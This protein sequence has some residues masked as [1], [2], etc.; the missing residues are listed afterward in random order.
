MLDSHRSTRRNGFDTIVVGGGSAGCVLASRLSEDGG[1]NVLLLEAGGWDRSPYLRIPAG[2]L[3]IAKSY[4]WRYA[5]EPDDTRAGL[6]DHW[7]AGRVLGGGSS[8]NGMMW[9]R[10]HR[11]D[12]D[13]WAAAGCDG[14]SAADVQP[15][16]EKSETFENGPA[17]GR[18]LSGPVHV[19]F[20]RSPQPVTEVFIRAAQQAG[21][22]WNDDFNGAAQEG[23]SRGQGSLRRGWR[24]STVR[25]YLAPAGHRRNL[26]IRTGAVVHRVL[27]DGTRAAGVEYSTGG[28]DVQSVKCRGEVILSAGTFASPKLLMLSGIGPAGPLRAHGIEVLCDRPGVGQNL[29]EHPY[30]T[31]MYGVSLHTLNRDLN[32]VGIARHGL[33]FVFRGRGALATPFGHGIVFGHLDGG[34]QGP[35]DLQITFAPFGVGAGKGRLAETLR[36]LAEASDK[37]GDDAGE[38]PAHRHDVHDMGLLPESSVTVMACVLHPRGRGAVRLRSADPAASP[39][40]DHR[41]FAEPEDVRAM[42]AACRA[43]RAI[44][45]A[46]ALKEVVTGELLPGDAV[47]SSADWDRFVRRF[48]F[49]GEHGVGTCRMGRDEDAVVDP[50]LRVVGVEGLRVVDASVMPAVPSG[51]TN[52]P[53]IMIAER[54]ADFIRGALPS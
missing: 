53:T 50:Q 44:F 35:S 38:E 52:A 9:V 33:S 42:G 31:L 51:N 45:D 22:G 27:F 15:Y 18:G 8:I 10:G 17:P 16:F 37:A 39:V 34:D 30:A 32:P 1:R 20:P 47:Q 43:V 19:A 48:G 46:T 26:T 2:T 49:R 12:F 29:Q 14:W 6:V 23:V 7:A 54:G 24:H 5:A 36:A 11:A 40:I 13:G 4:D 21:Y 3:K 41:L 28:G 25:A